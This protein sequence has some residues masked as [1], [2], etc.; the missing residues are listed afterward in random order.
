[1]TAVPVAHPERYSR[2]IE[3]LGIVATNDGPETTPRSGPSF[4]R[5]DT[6]PLGRAHEDSGWDGQQHY[7][8]ADFVSDTFPAQ[9]RPDVSFGGSS[10]AAY[11]A[12][13]FTSSLGH[14]HDSR[15]SRPWEFGGPVR[16][17]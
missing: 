3:F 1:L 16:T 2:A 5:D 6:L 15:G 12:G 11:I 14:R 10:D 8:F 13:G 7:R 9:P 17:G 4:D